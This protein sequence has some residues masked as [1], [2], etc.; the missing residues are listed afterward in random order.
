MKLRDSVIPRFIA[1]LLLISVS[2]SFAHAGKNSSVAKGIALSNSYAGNSWRQTM[3]KL[4]V[5]SAHEAI[6]RGMIAK[7]IVVD[8]DNSAAQQVTQIR[9]LIK[10]GWSAIAIDAVSPTGLNGVIQQAC[11]SHIIVVVFDSLATAPCAYKIIYDYQ[12]MGSLEAWYVANNLRVTSTVLEVRGIPGTSVDEEIH[13][14]VMEGF[15]KYP[16]IVVVGS[17]YGYWTESIAR[18]AVT[19][20]LPSLQKIDAI[21]TQGGD[22]LGVYEAFARADRPTPLIIMGN[23]QS[24]LA[25]WKRL[26]Q[27]SGGYGTISVSSAPG[28]SSIAFWVA[29]MILA[30]VNVP[31]TIVVPWLVVTQDDL[32]AWLRVVPPGGVATPLYDEQWTQKLIAAT[33]T[34]E[35]LP[36]SPI[37]GEIP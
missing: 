7:T 37:P 25:L 30:G 10:G 33:L 31:K 16:N 20:V 29:Q 13:K 34:H 17:V 1:A 14:G 26:S 24:E 28:V 4:W 35:A 12:N 22:A 8:A 27:A 36:Q 18:Q 6:L 2:G 9:D 21:V 5:R 15:S 32:D 3:L 23:R 19:D 11:R